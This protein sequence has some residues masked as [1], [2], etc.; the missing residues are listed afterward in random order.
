[1]TRLTRGTTLLVAS[2]VTAGALVCAPVSP[3]A[4]V[5]TH[6]GLVPENP[7]RGYP[8]V[9]DS[10][11]ITRPN[12][13]SVPREVQAAEQVGNH[14]VGGGNFLQVERPNGTVAAAPYFTAWT[15]D[16]KQLLCTSTKFN[17]EVMAL[18][19][20][21]GGTS[22]YVGG[23]FSSITGPDGV[24]RKRTKIAKILLPSCAVDLTFV[25]PALTNKVDELALLGN[26]LFVGGDFSTIGGSAVSTLAELNATTGAVNPAFSLTFSGGLTSRIRAMALNPAG[27][28]LVI[29]GRFGTVSRNGV[30]AT[31]PTAVVD[32]TGASPVLTRHSST[33]YLNSRGAA[34]PIADLLD[35]AVSPDATVVGLTY[36]TATTSDYVYLTP[37][38]EAAGTRYRWR[39]YMR[40]SGFGIGISNRAVYVTG[41][42]CKP[43]GGPGTTALMAPKP[44]IAADCSGSRMAGGVWRSKLA[45]LSLTDGTPL[46]WNPGSHSFRGGRE[47]TVVPRGLLIGFDGVRTNGVRTGA[48]AFL[49]FNSP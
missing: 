47:I 14:I 2:L 13:D 19:A 36:G 40:D 31:N 45:A 33:G 9:L 6:P 29:A 5:V 30:S 18:A 8:V 41:H 20:G 10:P 1:M 23:A 25:S 46:T 48:L 39:H 21:P 15:L 3:A 27:T 43:D 16:T 24:A 7:A 22:V 38:T 44:G 37:T 49:D 34:M 32:I 11:D 4:A 26:R 35:A 17:G 28:R 12:G 42:F